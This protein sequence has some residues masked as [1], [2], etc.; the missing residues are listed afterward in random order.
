MSSESLREATASERLSLPEEY[1]MQKSWREDADKQTFILSIPSSGIKSLS[2]SQDALRREYTVVGG[3]D[4]I[5]ANLVGDVNLFLYE[6]D[7]EESI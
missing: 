4:D 2:E 3:V 6:A 1:A 7:D 5:P